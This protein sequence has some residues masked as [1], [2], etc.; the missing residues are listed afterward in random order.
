MAAIREERSREFQK[1]L[2]GYTD[3]NKDVIRSFLVE[4]EQ[5]GNQHMYPVTIEPS[6]PTINET[7]S[8]DA[9][10]RHCSDVFAWRFDHS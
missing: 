6:S 9:S 7:L 5:N 4:A 3:K 10:W 1:L 8:I 2:Y